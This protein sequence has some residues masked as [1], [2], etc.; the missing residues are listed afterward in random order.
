MSFYTAA[1]AQNRAASELAARPNALQETNARK[2]TWYRPTLLM[3][4]FK[5]RIGYIITP[6]WVSKRV[7]QA[8][9]TFAT[10]VSTFPPRAGGF[11][12][13]LPV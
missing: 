4:C 10:A 3:L 7:R 1:R 11:E 9:T 6:E 12:A 8:L 13:R 5:F 2:R